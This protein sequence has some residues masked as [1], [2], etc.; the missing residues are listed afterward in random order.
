RAAATCSR[1]HSSGSAGGRSARRWTSASTVGA[2]RRC[3]RR[4]GAAGGQGGEHSVQVPQQGPAVD[5][6]RRWDHPPPCPG[7]ERLGAVADGGRHHG[8]AVVA[9]F[10]WFGSADAHLLLQTVGDLLG[11]SLCRGW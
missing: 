4:G 7:F 3:R 6:Y 8:G 2:L 11:V 5:L 9:G 10:R 1:S